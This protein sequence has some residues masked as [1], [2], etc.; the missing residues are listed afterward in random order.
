MSGHIYSKEER[1]W[2]I[3]QDPSLSYKEIAKIFNEKFNQ[4]VDWYSIRR[5]YLKHTNIRRTGQKGYFQKG[6]DP[7]YPTKVPIGTER[8]QGDYIFIKVRDDVPENFTKNQIAHY[9]WKKK[10]H[11]IWE[12]H[13]E[14]VKEG[15]ILIHLDR[16]LSNCNIENL[17]LVTRRVH[18]I[19]ARQK[20]YDL[21]T[22]ELVKTALKCAEL[23][24]TVTEVQNA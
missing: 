5:F 18:A 7:Y 6:H 2:L 20:W 11:Y 15:E 22:V 14:P 9:Q 3:S 17:Y 13:H 1:S 23:I 8:K 16:D 19:M 12:Q 24:A 4:D 10:S 21:S